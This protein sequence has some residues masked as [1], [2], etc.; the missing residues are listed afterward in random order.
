MRALEDHGLIICTYRRQDRITALLRHFTF[1]K[2]LPAHVVIV[3]GQR[4]GEKSHFPEEAPLEH[5]GIHFKLITCPP[6]TPLQRAEGMANLPQSVRFVH[7]IDDDFIPE[8]D[9][10]DAL[11]NVFDTRKEIAGAGGLFTQPVASFSHPKWRQFFGLEDER[12]GAILKTG[13]TTLGQVNVEGKTEPFPVDWLSG[14]SMSYRRDV[15]EKITFP[16]ELEGYA[17]DEDLIISSQSARYGALI[18]VAGARG[19]HDSQKEIRSDK[20]WFFY[21]IA[22]RHHAVKFYLSD[23]TSLTKFWTATLVRLAWRLWRNKFRPMRLPAFGYNVVK[24]ITLNNA[25]KMDTFRAN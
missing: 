1:M 18:A 21:S 20:Q 4:P 10:F 12:G 2:S 3:N 13:Y 14:C 19:R 15:L 25:P 16:S 8:P 9:Y 7:F 22:A 11:A 6:S 23:K 17:M 24:L 5:E